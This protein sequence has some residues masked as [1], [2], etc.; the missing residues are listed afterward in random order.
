MSPRNIL[1]FFDEDFLCNSTDFSLP[2]KRFLHSPSPMYTPRGHGAF[3]CLFAST[4]TRTS[5]RPKP[6]SLGYELYKAA[7]RS[8]PRLGFVV[9]TSTW[10]KTG[11][12]NWKPAG[13]LISWLEYADI[14]KSLYTLELVSLRRVSS[15]WHFCMSTLWRD[16]ISGVFDAGTPVTGGLRCGG[17]GSLITSGTVVGVC[18]CGVNEVQQLRRRYTYSVCSILYRPARCNIP[19]TLIVV[20]SRA[21]QSSMPARAGIMTASLKAL[22][23]ITGPVASPL[24]RL[25]WLRYS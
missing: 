3:E 24:G 6:Q 14:G 8:V 20:E 4:P 21:S 7:E 10:I 18:R 16:C 23:A 13:V 2:A 17:R 15:S 12:I 5:S 25:W 11:S 9:A 1:V 19:T 22:G